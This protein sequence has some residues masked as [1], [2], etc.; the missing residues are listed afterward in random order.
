MFGSLIGDT[1][2]VVILF[3][4]LFDDDIYSS[5]ESN[6]SIEELQYVLGDFKK[7]NNFDPNDEIVEFYLEF[8]DLLEEELLRVIGETWMEDKILGAVNSTFIELIPP[9]MTSLI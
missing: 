3:P 2:K 4:H 6:V 8:D 7:E 5:M 9:K 1:L